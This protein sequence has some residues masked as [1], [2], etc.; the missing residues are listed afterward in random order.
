ML[1][2]SRCCGI[3]AAGTSLGTVLGAVIGCQTRS[4]CKLLPI[5][6]HSFSVGLWQ[7]L[8][9]LEERMIHYSPQPADPSGVRSTTD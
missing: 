6:C 5:H 4:L 2:R 8:P 1:N 7:L 9:L 3:P